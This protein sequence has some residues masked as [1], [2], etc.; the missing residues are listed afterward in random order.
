MAL[1]SLLVYALEAK[2]LG[3]S[4]PQTSRPTV[5]C[6]RSNVAGGSPGWMP[7]V[8]YGHSSMA[9]CECCSDPSWQE[10]RCGRLRL[11]DVRLLGSIRRY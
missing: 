7:T 5:C 3:P 9:V 8:L 4:F 6:P 1:W 10:R 2:N 11:A